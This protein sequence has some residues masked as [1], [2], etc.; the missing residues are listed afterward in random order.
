[1]TIGAEIRKEKVTPNGTPDSTKPINNGTAEQE[2]K[3]VTVPSKA[4]STLPTYSRLWD[5]MR[6][7]RSGENQERITATQKMMIVNSRKILRV[8]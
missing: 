5:R 2:Q 4:A 7:V 1:L 8:S 6:R 3:G